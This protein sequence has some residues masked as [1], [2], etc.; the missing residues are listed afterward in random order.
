MDNIITNPIANIPETR[1]I[2]NDCDR[3][4]G[5]QDYGFMEIKMNLVNCSVLRKVQFS[6]LAVYHGTLLLLFE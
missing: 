1:Y 4:T 2:I 3:T 6:E 5:P